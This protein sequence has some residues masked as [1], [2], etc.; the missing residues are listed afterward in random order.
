[1]E[2]FTANNLSLLNKTYTAKD[3][4]FR[5]VDLQDHVA[6]DTNLRKQTSLPYP[7]PPNLNLKNSIS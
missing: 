7:P 5:T 2:D 3:N 1:M 4:H 6:L